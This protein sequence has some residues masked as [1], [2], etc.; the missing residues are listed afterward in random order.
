MARRNREHQPV[1][2]EANFDAN[3]PLDPKAV[4]E[5][6]DKASSKLRSARTEYE[7]VAGIIRI[8]KRV[9]GGVF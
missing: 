9:F 2:L 8:T 5:F 6:L 4:I 3:T 1:K 7:A